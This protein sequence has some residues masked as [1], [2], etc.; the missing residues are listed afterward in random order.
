MKGYCCHIQDKGGRVRACQIFEASHDN[1]VF[2]RV[3]DY[4]AQH[5]AV[6]AVEVWLEGRYVGKLHQPILLGSLALP[7][8]I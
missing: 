7:S 1:E 5:P 3:N 8:A 4:L 2:G 6:Q